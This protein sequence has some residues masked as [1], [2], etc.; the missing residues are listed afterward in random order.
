MRGVWHATRT[1]GPVDWSSIPTL[2]T[3]FVYYIEIGSYKVP[4]MY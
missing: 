4:G 3:P 1:A 2:G